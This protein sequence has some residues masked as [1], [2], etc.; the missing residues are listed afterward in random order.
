MAQGAYIQWLVDTHPEALE[1]KVLHIIARNTLGYRKRYAYV[2]EELFEMSHNKKW[3]QV[4]K[5]KDMNL[6]NYKKTRGYTMYK[7]I[8]PNNIEDSIQWEKGRQQEEKVKIPT[9]IPGGWK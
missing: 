2:K 4:K 1:L 6:L 7:L 8:L 9:E 5:L 3:R